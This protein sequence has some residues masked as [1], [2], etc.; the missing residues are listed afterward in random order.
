MTTTDNRAAEL[1]QHFR[2]TVP[3][4]IELRTP[5]LHAKKARSRKQYAS[6]IA[7]LREA[8]LEDRDPSEPVGEQA[9]GRPTAPRANRGRTTAADGIGVDDVKSALSMFGEA[10]CARGASEAAMIRALATAYEVAIRRAQAALAEGSTSARNSEDEVFSWHFTSIL[11][12]FAV[13]TNDSDKS[14]RNR[15][16][17]AFALVNDFPEWVV[18][19]ENGRIDM[20]HVRELLKFARTLESEFFAEYG[21]VVLEFAAQH[22]PAE[23]ARFAEEAASTIAAEDTEDAFERARAQRY[24]SIQHDGYGMALLK[25]YLPSEIATPIGQLL[26]KG[27]RE[28]I[29]LDKQA[30]AEHAQARRAAKASGAAEPA[31]FE[32]DTRSIGQLRADILA[33]TLLC[34]T[35]GK[36]R[37]KALVSITVPALTLLRGRNN[38]TAPALIDGMTPMSFDEARQIAAEAPSFQR[39]LTDPVSGH[40]VS[41]D[42][43]EPNRALRRFL[44]VRDRTCLFPGCIRPAAQCETDHTQPFSEGGKTNDRNLGHLCKAHHVQKHEKPWSVTNL[45]GGVLQWQTPLGQVVTARPRPY[46]PVFVPKK[47]P[48]PPPF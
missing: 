48:D 16:Y 14:L 15:G 4:P 26:D 6:E 30:K 39:V 41:V 38:G 45:G 37:V 31:E 27:A 36:S 40:V 11:G 13:S 12:E 1:A 18:A 5:L 29:D 42:T 17:D 32:P 20:R 24:V 47:N 8:R 43:Y 25:A 2:D 46:G 9:P 44:Q 19:L 3:A 23:T 10:Y 21:S 28:L 7:R 35:P 22:T 33:E 34:S